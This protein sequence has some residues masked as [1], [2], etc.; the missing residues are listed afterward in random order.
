MHFYFIST[1]T[2]NPSIVDIG[3]RLVGVMK[4]PP[5]KVWLPCCPPPLVVSTEAASIDANLWMVWILL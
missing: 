4:V 1:A 2:I 5:V 3:D